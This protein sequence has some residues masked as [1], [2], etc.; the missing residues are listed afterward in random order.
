MAEEQVCWQLNVKDLIIPK[1]NTDDDDSP[2]TLLSFVEAFKPYLK[3]P[4]AQISAL[5]QV[6]LL[7]HKERRW[8]IELEGNA[9]HILGRI[10]S[11]AKKSGQW[12]TLTNKVTRGERLHPDIEEHIRIFKQ[13]AQHAGWTLESIQTREWFVQTIPNL[14]ALTARMTNAQGELASFEELEMAARS[15]ATVSRYCDKRGEASVADTERDSEEEE[16]A[17]AARKKKKKKNMICRRCGK[18]GHTAEVCRARHPNPQS[19]RNPNVKSQY[20]GLVEGQVKRQS[21]TIGAKS[22][23]CIVDTGASLNIITKAAAR[24]VQRKT[25]ARVSTTVNT[26]DSQIHIERTIETEIKIGSTK[27]TVTLHVTPQSTS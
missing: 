13:V 8:F 21:V 14:M 7:G 9:E 6:A 11:E 24:R 1:L 3:R 20:V 22:F 16:A 26:L 4:P 17:Y 15:A 10:A 19:A 2:L 5:L 25:T 18:R 23:S 27:A 12:R